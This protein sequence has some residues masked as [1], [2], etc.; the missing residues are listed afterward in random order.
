MVS[1][2]ETRVSTVA[3]HSTDSGTA[4]DLT[5]VSLQLRYG[6]MD[7]NQHINN[8]QIARLFEESRVRSFGQWFDDGG[9][10]A[11]YAMVVG[12]QDIVFRAVLH[13]SLEPVTVRTCINRIGTS[14]F[15]MLLTLVD[16]TGT[17]CAVAETT[18]VSVDNESG[19]ATPVPDEVRAVLEAHLVEG[20]ELLVRP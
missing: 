17:T 10:P 15:R 8:V 11:E 16:P 18:M 1:D 19:R 2:R 3:E 5:S 4:G 20:A 7:I 6:D 13:Y 12:R 14:S 9:R